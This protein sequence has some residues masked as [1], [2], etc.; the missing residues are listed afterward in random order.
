MSSE[1]RDE[2][3]EKVDFVLERVKRLSSL[4]IALRIMSSHTIGEMPRSADEFRVAV[5]S[6]ALSQDDAVS[7]VLDA[8]DEIEDFL[9]H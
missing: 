3:I 2:V 5:E 6:I 1:T 8:L 7:G 9:R 4:A